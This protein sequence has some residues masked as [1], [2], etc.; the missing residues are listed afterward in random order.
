[1]SDETAFSLQLDDDTQY[2]EAPHVP[3]Y[4]LS[5]TDFTVEAWIK[6]KAA[7]QGGPV[8]TSMGAT[9]ME[10]AGWGLFLNDDATLRFDTFDANGNYFNATSLESTTA[11][12]GSWHHVAVVRRAQGIQLFFDGVPLTPIMALN[13]GSAVDVTSNLGLTVGSTSLIGSQSQRSVFVG[14]L[15]EARLWNRALE[16]WELDQGIYH[17]ME[18]N[19]PSLIGQWGFDDKTAAD[20]SAVGNHGRLMGGAG[21]GAPAFYFVPEGQPFVVVQSLMMQD[22]AWSPTAGGSHDDETNYR[23]AIQLRNSDGS[24]RSGTVTITSDVA[25]TIVCQGQ[26]SRIDETKGATFQTNTANQVNLTLAATS[27][28]APVL[29]LH[30]DFMDDDERIVVPVDRQVHHKLSQLD[31]GDLRAGRDPLLSPKEF[32]EDQADA[33]ANAVNNMMAAAVQHDMQP[34]HDLIRSNAT[35][36][37]LAPRALSTRRA[38][39]LADNTVAPEWESYL[40]V[41]MPCPCCDHKS[42]LIKCHYLALDGPVSRRVINGFM[43]VKHFAFDFASKTFTP[44]H[45]AQAH[46]LVQ[47]SNVRVTRRAA[48]ALNSTDGSLWDKFVNGLLN[49]VDVLVSAAE[50]I[51]DGVRTVITYIED[52]VR[53]VFDFVVA[54]VEDAIDFVVGFFKQL[55]VALAKLI[56]F[57]KALFDWDDILVTHRVLSHFIDESFKYAEACAGDL[58]ASADAGLEAAK[59]AIQTRFEEM[60]ARLGHRTPNQM[61]KGATLQPPGAIRSAYLQQR[62]TEDPHSA[63]LTAGDT[64]E[65]AVT[66]ALQAAYNQQARLQ[67]ITQDTHGLLEEFFRD[68]HAAMNKALVG[69]LDAVEKGLVASIDV[70]KAVFDAMMDLFVA[71]LHTIHGMLTTEIQIPFIT[72]LYEE[73][74]TGDGSKLTAVDLLALLGALPCTVIYKLERHGKAPFSSRW[75]D[76]FQQTSYSDWGVMKLPSQWGTHSSALMLQDGD[77][78]TSRASTPEW[79]RSLSYAQSVLFGFAVPV[80]FIS[81]GLA[82]QIKDIVSAGARPKALKWLVAAEV[83]AQVVSF[84]LTEDYGTDTTEF[85]ELMIWASQFIP[86]AFDIV[87]LTAAGSGNNARYDKWLD[88]VGPALTITYGLCH[89]G[90]FIYLAVREADDGNHSTGATVLKTVSN[91]ITTFPELGQALVLGDAGK[92]YMVLCIAS[93]VAVPVLMIPRVIIAIG[94]HKKLEAR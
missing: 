26:S 64:S 79:L 80:W 61:Q 20:S 40:P 86:L 53:K 72:W 14:A 39:R 46:S 17:V 21:F 67:T 22:Y 91:C 5:T 44:V 88:K 85:V 41:D 1:M 70:L 51:A 10:G 58:K 11:Y 62:V 16:S 42:D 83:V 54:T 82:S 13:T 68:P 63:D 47:S 37:A 38:I 55:G 27:L 6:P 9:V 50:R 87:A 18:T 57:L 19:K 31:G 66:A 36:A 34:K 2:M 81:T 30:A 48:R 84:P 29:K 3:T 24:P 23:L 56:D 15:D 35:F 45:A 43:P 32:D 7:G 71:G 4:D 60:K 76:D 12:D 75:A 33:V 59:A 65:P 90:G 73:V 25:A 28:L 52:G 94:E 74:I 92:Y 77:E 78:P 93:G 49:V 89:L 69:L 8:V